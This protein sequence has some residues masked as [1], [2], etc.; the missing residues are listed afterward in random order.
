MSRAPLRS[1]DFT[2]LIAPALLLQLTCEVGTATEPDEA[3]I[4]H[5]SLEAWGEMWGPLARVYQ[6]PA[7]P[8]DGSEEE[9]L[10]TSAPS[11]RDILI[12]ITRY[13]LYMRHPELLSVAYGKHPVERDYER[14][15]ATMAAVVAGTDA[16][17]G[18]D[19]LEPATGPT[20]GAAGEGLYSANTPVYTGATFR[21]F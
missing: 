5:V 17:E 15:L 2:G 21:G 10:A 12:R 7:L 8:V 13:R 9:Y 4:G 14:A 19:P 20:D 18:L 16:I 11:A 6:R 1:A 3:V